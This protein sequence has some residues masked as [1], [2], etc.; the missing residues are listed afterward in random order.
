MNGYGTVKLP[1]GKQVNVLRIVEEST[2]NYNGNI[3]TSTVIKLFSN[4]GE[5]ISISPSS[6]ASLDGEIAIE[7]VSWTSGGGGQVVEE[8]PTAPDQ[9]SAQTNENSITLSW[10]DNS[11]NETGFYIERSGGSSVSS[12]I[13]SDVKSVVVDSFVLIDSTTADVNTYTDNDVVPGVEYSYRVRAYNE[14][15]TSATVR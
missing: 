15:G 4:T 11:N 1:G 7:N 2:F 9:L 10:V 12:V 3:S 14:S 6:E 5:I 8:A 13:T